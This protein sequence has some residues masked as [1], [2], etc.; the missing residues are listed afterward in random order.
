LYAALLDAAGIEHELGWS[1]DASP[2]ASLTPDDPFPSPQRWQQRL[3]VLVKPKDAGPSWCDLSVHDLPYGRIL[4]NASRAEVMTTHGVVSLPE[5]SPDGVRGARLSI[6]LDVEA[7]G[8]AKATIDYEQT[9]NFGY[10][11][12]DR[13]KETPEARRKAD[14]GRMFAGLLSGFEL[15]TLETPGLDDDEPLSFVGHGR[16]AKF[17]DQSD[18]GTTAKLPMPP[19][20]LTNGLAGGEGERKFPYYL[21][22]S[23]QSETTVEITLPAGM[24]LADGPPALSEESH[25]CRYELTTDASTPG[26]IRITRKFELEPFLLQPEEYPG[27]AAFCA[28]ADE[29]ERVP[30]RF[31]TQ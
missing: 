6:A 4:G 7:D 27:F 24:H 8:G 28:K 3:L 19:M 5:L 12:K 15:S 23:F 17:L 2:E 1:R 25:G 9:G 20:E 13:Y 14:G 10:V 11:N 21:R 29:V 16:V 26:K 22:N 31:V 18:T 30:L